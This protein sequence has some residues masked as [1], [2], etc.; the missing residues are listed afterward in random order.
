MGQLCVNVTIVDDNILEGNED[1]FANLTS[2]DPVVILNPHEATASIS[3][4][5][6]DSKGTLHVIPCKFNPGIA[7]SSA[8]MPL[9]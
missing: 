6:T 1:F 2:T 5:S 4:D 7:G 8:T 9:Y 3:E